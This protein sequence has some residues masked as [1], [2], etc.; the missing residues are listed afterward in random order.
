LGAST[1]LKFLEL[2]V[3]DG[4]PVGLVESGDKVLRFDPATG[5]PLP[6]SPSPPRDRPAPSLHGR[7]K[8]WHRLQFIG[9]SVG[10]LMECFNALIGIGLFIMIITG[11]VLYFQ[12]LRARVRGGRTAIFWFSGGWW[13]SAHRWISVVASAFL[14]V[15]SVTGTL[16]SI[17]TVS[18]G[19]YGATHASAP[20]RFPIGITGDFSSPLPDPQL[21]AMLATTLSAY[22]AAQGN[23]PIKVVRLR[24]FSGMPQGVIVTGGDQT[25]QLVFNA[26]TGKR[27][28]MTEPGYPYTGFPFGWEEHELVKR[29]HRGDAF[30]IPG[31]LMDVFAGLSLVFLSTSGL[32]MYL[33]LLRKRRR[34]GRKQ[35]FWV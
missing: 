31:R 10:D 26:V 33:D 15:V 16:L 17:D 5:A 19:V 11:L 9:G 8:Q 7:I 22:R 30:G 34:V 2:R 28:S 12:L 32:Y 18:M 13:R 23:T 1:P 27:V 24:Y 3:I 6:G 14:L 20:S 35:M 21:P 29:I 4:R 25:R